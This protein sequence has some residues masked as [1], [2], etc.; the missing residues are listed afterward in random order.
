MSLLS[1]K[2]NKISI[3]TDVIKTWNNFS[4]ISAKDCRVLL[5]VLKTIADS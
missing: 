1:I 3:S 4:D 5:G 2:S